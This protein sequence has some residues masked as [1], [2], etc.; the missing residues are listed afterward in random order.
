MSKPESSISQGVGMYVHDW[1]LVLLLII[2]GLMGVI[3]FLLFLIAI[4]NAIEVERNYK[5]EE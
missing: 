3:N 5:T 2:S 1:L 4:G